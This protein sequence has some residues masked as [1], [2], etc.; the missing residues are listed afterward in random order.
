VCCNDGRQMAEM[1]YCVTFLTFPVAGRLE[2]LRKVIDQLDFFTCKSMEI[3]I[4]RFK[5]FSI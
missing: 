3:D 2:E 5:Y 1:L 4:S